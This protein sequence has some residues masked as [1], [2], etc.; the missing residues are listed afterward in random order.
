MW[1]YTY[2]DISKT[3]NLSY[4]MYSIGM[5]ELQPEIIRIN[6]FPY[7]Q[8]FYGTKGTGTLTINKKSY[9]INEYDG[10]FIP[11]NIPHSYK[12]DSDV[13]DLR[14]MLPGGEGLKDLYNALGLTGGVYKIKD[15]GL[16]DT[17]L[18]NAHNEYIADSVSGALV[19]SN[20]VP[21]FLTEFARQAGVL[22]TSNRPEKKENNIYEKHMKI[23]DD[24]IEYHFMIHI[25]MEVLCS[26]TKMSPQHVC[27]II[28]A[29]RGMRPMEYISFCRI[30]HAKEIIASSDEKLSDVAY[31]CGFENENYFW[32]M[33]RKFTGMTPSKYRQ[34][35]RSSKI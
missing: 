23:I 34:Y 26:L 16:L 14:W 2:L 33:F 4:Y 17:I 20:M 25:D 32:K 30:N 29:C 21:L 24:Y 1:Y 22:P 5:H 15:I 3:E 10:F 35:F 7:D 18:N 12:P 8:F 6:G 11:A 13:W 28:K 27:R 9:H 31:L 19:A